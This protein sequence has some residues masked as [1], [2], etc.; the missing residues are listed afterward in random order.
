MRNCLLCSDKSYFNEKCKTI[1]SLGYNYDYCIVPASGAFAQ[2]DVAAENTDRQI[3]KEE[4]KAFF[5]DIKD[6]RKALHDQ[7]RDFND[8]RKDRLDDSDQERI[9]V[10]PTLSFKGQT[11]GWAVINDKAYPTEF[12][13]E[14]KAG[15]TKQGWQLTGTGTVFVGEREITFD[16]KGFAKNNHIN[17]KG[18]SQDDDSVIIHL[19][20]N[21]TPI[22]ESE[23]SFALAFTRAAL[24][25]EDSDVKVPLVLVGDIIVEP[26]IFDNESVS[27]ETDFESDIPRPR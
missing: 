2:S 24:V 20:G 15:H 3:D 25:I 4:R 18:V 21:F 7:I 12:T 14:G 8:Q 22:A 10:E 13:L 27:D 1:F 19:K 17:M 23:N 5:D 6:Q 26:I 16:L 9:S 11:S